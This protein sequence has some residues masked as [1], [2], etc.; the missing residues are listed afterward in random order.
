MHTSEINLVECMKCL[1]VREKMQPWIVSCVVVW[2][3][4]CV[5]AVVGRGRRCRRRC[6]CWWCWSACDFRC[7]R[8]SRSRHSESSMLTRWQRWRSRRRCRQSATTTWRQQSAPHV[9]SATV[10]HGVCRR[11]SLH[12]TTCHSKRDVNASLLQAYELMLH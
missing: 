8:S 4:E 11:L 12:N 6:C 2:R 5:E 10:E 3:V 1:P 7:P 9:T